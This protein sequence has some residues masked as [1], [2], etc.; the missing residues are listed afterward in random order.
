MHW[1]SRAAVMGNVGTNLSSG[2]RR[3]V[4]LPAER[5]MSR[6]EKNMEMERKKGWR[7]SDTIEKRERD[8]R[9]KRERDC[10]PV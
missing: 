10:N 5:T 4:I 1:A 3:T 9:K 7:D 8:R 2:E 6:E